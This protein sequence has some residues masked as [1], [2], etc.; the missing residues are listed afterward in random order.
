MDIH[1]IIQAEYPFTQPNVDYFL[2]DDGHGPYV[3]RWLITGPVP[4][5]VSMGVT[6]IQSFEEIHG[7][8]RTGAQ[9]LLRKADTIQDLLN[10]NPQIEAEA[11]AAEPGAIIGNTGMVKE[12]VLMGI[13]L[14]ASFRAYAAT[15]LAPGI[16]V[17]NAVWRL[18]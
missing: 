16:T 2:Q 6:A 15:E 5:G 17:R 9:E 1:A 8:M 10:A 14:I 18:G 13:A 12:E 11:Q 7:T 3:I 4:A